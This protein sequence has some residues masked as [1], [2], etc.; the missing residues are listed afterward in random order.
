MS[1]KLRQLTFPL[2]VL[3]LLVVLGTTALASASDAADPVL[4]LSG[5][6]PVALVQGEELEGRENLTHVH[7]MWLYRF[8]SEENL[9]AFQAEPDRFRIQRDDCIVVPGAEVDPGIFTVHGGKIYVF[10]TDHCREEF[11]SA[12]ALFLDGESTSG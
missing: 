6:D 12:P 4:A 7:G 3:L 9:E 8:A 1:T 11:E 2:A 10:A 5:L